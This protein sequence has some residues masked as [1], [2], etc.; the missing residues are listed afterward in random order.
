MIDL[1]LIAVIAWAGMIGW[2][3]GMYRALLDAVSTLIAVFFVT[4]S[5]P[6]LKDSII[7]GAWRLG[8]EHW[9]QL[10]LRDHHTVFL[11]V[12]QG[13]IPAGAQITSSKAFLAERIYEMIM[14]SVSAF[15]LIM[16]IQLILQVYETVWTPPRGTRA[17]SGLGMAVG[18]FLGIFI[19]LFLINGLGMLSWFS[20]MEVLDEHL[21]ESVLVSVFVRWLP[22]YF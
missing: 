8:F 18:L 14:I 16:G 11:H 22:W 7:D 17:N 4:I 15:A 5:V 10:R 12:E 20:G 2:M 9:I 19:V 21:S 13:S 6:I 3:R 1:I